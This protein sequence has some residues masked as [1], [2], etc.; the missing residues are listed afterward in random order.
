MP[1]IARTYDYQDPRD[2]SYTFGRFERPDYE[3]RDSNGRRAERGQPFAPREAAQKVGFGTF[4]E[5]LAE[6][7][8][9]VLLRAAEQHKEVERVFSS[10]G[11][12]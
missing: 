1:K 12:R 5:S 3:P 2:P 6:F 11:K 9:M 10:E 7:I 4:P 8:H